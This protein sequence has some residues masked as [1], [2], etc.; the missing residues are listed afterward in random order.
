[1]TGGA[2]GVAAQPA[3]VASAREINAVLNDIG[4]VFFPQTPGQET[5]GE[6]RSVRLFAR[7]LA[8]RKCFV[9]DLLGAV[10]APAAATRHTQTQSGRDT[11]SQ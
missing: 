11:K 2:E 5:R 8:G 9:K 6:L 4:S 7:Q 3:N 10:G 1:M